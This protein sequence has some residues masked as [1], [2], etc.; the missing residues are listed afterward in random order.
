MV[1]RDAVDVV[2]ASVLHALSLGLERILVLDNGSSDGTR[3]VLRRLDRHGVPVAWRS[4]PG[5]YMQ[6][7]LMTGLVHEAS[8]EGADWVVPMD[9]DEF[10]LSPA[11]LP[12]LL[13]QVKR[14]GVLVPVT[15][16]VQRRDRL[17]P[18]PEG[19]LTMTMRVACTLD[20]V[21]SERLLREGG[22]GLVEARWP[23]KLLLRA[24]TDVRMHAG[25]HGADGIGD[26]EGTDWFELLHAPVRARSQ[27]LG[28]VEHAARVRAARP[29]GG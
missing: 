3:D 24:S 8:R 5:L 19:L 29:V 23:H 15:N 20:A 14:D 21:T 22:I 6:A 26:L 16:F 25:N 27:L 4:E 1:V 28:R 2:G 10:L 17:E 11:K 9:A 7:E 13:P 18:T 12:A